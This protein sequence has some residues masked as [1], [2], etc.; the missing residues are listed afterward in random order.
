M[1]QLARDKGY[2]LKIQLQDDLVV[3]V[4]MKIF[5]YHLMFGLVMR[6]QW[7]SPES[8]LTVE[9]PRPAGNTTLLFDW[10]CPEVAVVRFEYFRSW[11]MVVVVVLSILVL[12]RV[13]AKQ[14]DPGCFDGGTC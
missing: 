7:M 12:D 6:W 9:W 11:N 3:A 8:L 14:G 13:A 5:S 4:F 10:Q 2:K 1:R